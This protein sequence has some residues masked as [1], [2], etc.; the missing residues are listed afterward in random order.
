M[1]ISISSRSALGAIG[2][3]EPQT[4]EQDL[5][6]MQHCIPGQSQ[7][8]SDLSLGS[9]QRCTQCSYRYKCTDVRARRNSR[10]TV[11]VGCP[12]PRFQKGACR[13]LDRARPNR[14]LAC[15]SV[16]AS[17]TQARTCRH[18]LLRARLRR[19]HTVFCVSC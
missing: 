15:R 18:L 17:A 12:T 10:N 6:R 8:G 5:S 11:S 13:H 19:S 1:N 2:P 7:H 4:N 3:K 9:S 14:S 16:P